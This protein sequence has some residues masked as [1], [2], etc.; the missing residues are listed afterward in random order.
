MC[1]LYALQELYQKLLCILTFSVNNVRK[2]GF[3]FNG[4]CVIVVIDVV[5][6]LLECFFCWAGSCSIDV[7]VGLLRD[8]PDFANHN[9]GK[10]N[11]FQMCCYW[12]CCCLKPAI[13]CWF[14]IINKSSPVLKVSGKVC[15]SNSIL[16]T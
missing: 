1:S 10:E 2:S 11:C 3:S 4:I 9:A 8:V 16:A 5:W 14:C 15:P 6:L 13:S 7:F 12:C